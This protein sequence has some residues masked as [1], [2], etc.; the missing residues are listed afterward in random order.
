MR[1]NTLSNMQ[2]I[3]YPIDVEEARKSN[4]LVT[5]TNQQG[6]SKLVMALSDKLIRQG[7]QVV[8]FDNVGIWKK[9][10]SMR[11]YYEVSETTMK[12]ILPRGSMIYDISMLLPVF[13]KQFVE[14]V[15]ND[16]WR[17]RA[18]QNPRTWLLVVFEEFQLYAK[19]VRGNVSQNLLRIMSV[20]ANHRIRCLGITPDLSLIDC[21]FIR[22]CNQRYHFRLGNEPN[23]KRRFK[24][25]YGSD[26]CRIALE[27]DVGCCIY[28]LNEKLRPK[29]VPLFQNE[30]IPQP[31]QEPREPEKQSLWQKIVGSVTGQ[32]DVLSDEP[33]EDSLDE[34][35]E[36]DLGLLGEPD[37]EW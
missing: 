21:A 20:G 28:Y 37:S 36:E 1:E 25:Y 16:I 18:N 23:A 11:A 29:C 2:N 3:T 35:S 7:W 13:Q 12:Y 10:S 33:L 6:K 8:V 19:N 14:M 27:L 30:R 17:L 4:L 5:G 31:Y 34:E 9:Q 15:L 26:W 22:L 24:A 32:R